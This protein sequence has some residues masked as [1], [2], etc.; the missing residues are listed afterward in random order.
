[1]FLIF[2]LPG[3]AVSG[4][5]YGV[6]PVTEQGS[7]THLP[8][9]AQ[10]PRLSPVQLAGLSRPEGRLES[11]SPEIAGS[12]NLSGEWLRI[13]FSVGLTSLYRDF[14][15]NAEHIGWHRA[16]LLP[17]NCRMNGKARESR[18]GRYH[19]LQ[20][21]YNCTG[22]PRLDSV[23]L[24]PVAGIHPVKENEVLLDQARI[25]L[26][27]VTERNYRIEN[28][29]S[30]VGMEDRAGR[31][32]MG[33]LPP[34]VIHRGGVNKLWLA[35]SGFSRGIYQLRF[36]AED[37]SGC[38]ALLTVNMS[39]LIKGRLHQMR[40]HC[41]PSTIQLHGVWGEPDIEGCAELTRTAEGVLACR[42]KP[43]A[44]KLRVS[45]G[46]GWLPIDLSVKATSSND[47]FV[48]RQLRPVWPFSSRQYD[49][50]NT[51]SPGPHDSCNS[52][53][54][55]QPVEVRYWR[56]DRVVAEF[57]PVVFD[58][59]GKYRLPVIDKAADYGV[60]PDQF[61]FRMRRISRSKHYA[62]WANI[63]LEIGSSDIDVVRVF[64]RRL[65]LFDTPLWAPKTQSG[66]AYNSDFEVHFF[67]SLTECRN[68]ERSEDWR[69][70]LPG[71]M[72]RRIGSFCEYAK[73][74][75]AN[76]GIDVT[77]CTAPVLLDT[78]DGVRFYSPDIP[79]TRSRGVVY[80]FESIVCEGKRRVLVMSLSEDFDTIGGKRFNEAVFAAL[81]QIEKERIPFDLWLVPSRRSPELALRCEDFRR[82]GEGRF[83]E[84][85]DR[86]RFRGQDL[87]AGTDLVVALGD[88]GTGD[89][90]R[91]IYLTEGRNIHETSPAPS[92]LFHLSTQGTKARVLTLGGCHL[93]E[94]GTQVDRC[95]KM[96]AEDA[97]EQFSRQLQWLLQGTQG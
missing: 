92:Q 58:D 71:E 18:E 64:S 16:V 63:K 14:V 42:L 2:L 24:P 41:P 26:K 15:R 9:N 37:H 50:E 23:R 11:A 59:S 36:K 40:E 91:L 95:I 48:T 88:Y 78:W 96:T 35:A 8:G 70:Y 79:H 7:V 49:I 51:G 82:H 12:G 55:Y 93:W 6:S 25:P 60:L 85:H 53:P 57:Q 76:S 77:E 90:S 17:N 73:V 44:S 69:S 20:L 47:V 87:D 75:N 22:N 61:E 13:K 81:K 89:I 74:R 45:Y 67:P 72:A 32:K 62:E 1:M 30:E 28:R 65:M 10:G 54:V 34:T 5:V 3:L 4:S 84:L 66:L 56:G 43:A 68:Q 19:Q 33:D 31:V 38:S 86:M 52:L 27:I 46:R 80:T 97:V 94:R 29:P 83:D 21:F 39:D